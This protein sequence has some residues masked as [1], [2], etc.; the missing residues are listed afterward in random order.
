[1]TE[2]EGRTA[3]LSLVGTTPL[4]IW[5]ARS[6]QGGNRSFY[7]CDERAEYE[8][9]EL[10]INE[11]NPCDKVSFYEFGNFQYLVPLGLSTFSYL[12]EH[13]NPFHEYAIGV[14]TLRCEDIYEIYYVSDIMDF[15]KENEGRR[16]IFVNNDVD[17][18]IGQT[19]NY[20]YIGDERG[21]Y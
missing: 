3:L 11:L 19:E 12:W 5:V 13:D 8:D 2:N 16:A 6:R 18:Q 17:L 10:I 1:M 9:V 21:S 20:F 15:L 4:C 7:I 14:E